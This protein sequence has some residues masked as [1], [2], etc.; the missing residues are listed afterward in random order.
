M[1]RFVHTHLHTDR[2][3]MDGLSTATNVAKR[4]SELGQ[5]GFFITDHGTTAGLMEGYRAAKKYNLK[6]GFGAEFYFVRDITIK[7]RENYHMVLLAKN[8]TG[9]YNLLKLMTIAHQPENFYYKP[10]IDMEM[11]KQ[12]SEG[13]I[14]TTACMGGILKLEN[15]KLYLSK[16]KAIFGNDFYIELHTNT[17]EGQKEFNQEALLMGKELDIPFL[18]CCDSHYV[19]KSEAATHRAW[20]GIGENDENAYY[21]TDDFYIMSEMEVAK[22]L[23]YLPDDI[24]DLAMDNTSC[25]LDQCNVELDFKTKHYPEFPVPNQLEYL[26]SLCMEGFRKHFGEDIPYEY[27]E[28]YAYE[29]DVLTKAEYINYFLITYDILSWCHSNYIYTGVGRG[30]VTA[31]LVSYLMGITKIDPIKYDLLFERFA[32]LERVT[33]ADIDVD[34]PQSRRQEVID[35]IRSK[36][37]TVYQVRTFGLMAEKGALKRAGQALHIEPSLVNELSKKIH[38]GLD[39]IK[40]QHKL[41]AL[42]KNFMGVLQNNSVHASAVVVFP[43]DPCHFCAIEKQGDNY[44][45]AYDFHDLEALGVLKQDVLGLK[46]CDVIQ[47]TCDTVG[48]SYTK[49]DELPDVDEKTFEMLRK[50]ETTGC[51]QIEGYGMTK[52]VKDIQP[53]SFNDM[54]PIVALYRPGVIG[55]GM[56]DVFVERRKIALENNKSS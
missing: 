21:G 2:S 5:K 15:A 24:I 30:S 47:K 3:I 12:Y 36:Y 25:L 28:R 29:I 6:F 7:E 39:D 17:I 9:Y 48:I 34:V 13:L 44:V 16:L 49:I 50:G 52:L 45:A 18:A 51:F 56:L 46:T 26:K 33:P 55:A 35:Y 32:H 14:C 8:N 4:V 23:C 41:V 54:I 31:C 1:S 42:A 20:K 10:R 19:L 37:G 43:E 11:L 53:K 22:A 40:D 27:W 38:N